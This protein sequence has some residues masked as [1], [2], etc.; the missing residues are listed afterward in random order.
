MLIL[1]ADKHEGLFDDSSL[2]SFLGIPR[3]K[4]GD[5]IAE[6][7]KVGVARI[8]TEEEFKSLPAEEYDQ[9]ATIFTLG[10]RGL[11]RIQ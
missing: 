9:S 4:V 8:L 5:A 2:S 7:E 11:E 1:I 10:E 3:E 6:M